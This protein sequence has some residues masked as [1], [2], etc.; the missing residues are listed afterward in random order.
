MLK[1]EVHKVID[2]F[3]IKVGDD[4]Q[5]HNVLSQAGMQCRAG[6]WQV[7]DDK[8]KLFLDTIN[9]TITKNPKAELYFL[10][11]P[12]DTFN[13]V[14]VDIDLRFKATEEELKQKSQFKRRYTED[15]IEFMVDLL[16][17]KLGE[18]IKMPDSYKI[19]V[20]EK[21]NPRISY[22]EKQIKD[23]IHIVYPTLCPP[24]KIQFLARHDMAENPE[25][26]ELFKK[27]NVSND[28]AIFPIDYL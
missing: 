25:I 26:Q 23:G 22:Q 5:K 28:P 10:E 11:V 13:M 7:P 4:E 16:A 15:F 12:N 21:K 27:M 1:T 24:Y 20:Q 14:K 9:K 6:K 8:Y 18:I 3:R 17:S 19:Y 2:Q